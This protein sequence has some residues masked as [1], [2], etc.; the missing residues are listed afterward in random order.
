[1]RELVVDGTTGRVVSPGRP[2]AV[3]A[4]I[5]DVLGDA[6]GATAMRLAARRRVEERF[7]TEAMA[8]ATQEVY[9][10]ELARCARPT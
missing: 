1:V 8:R 4:A 6:T 5:A 9:A 2:E 3:A 7:S 10:R